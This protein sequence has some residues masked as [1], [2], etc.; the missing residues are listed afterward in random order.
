MT[1]VIIYLILGLITH[2]CGSWILYMTIKEQ[3]L[4]PISRAPYMTFI[5]L[6][7]AGLAAGVLDYYLALDAFKAM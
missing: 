6:G 2:S 4:Y 7:H 5:L 3:A 1:E